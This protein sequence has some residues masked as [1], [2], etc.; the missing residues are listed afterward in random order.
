MVVVGG[1]NSSNTCHLAA[2]SGRRGVTTFHI[3]DSDGID[4]VAGTIRHQPVGSKTETVT[5]GWLEGVHRIGLTAGAS[6]PNNKIGETVARI[7]ASAGI[8]LG[9]ALGRD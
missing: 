4:P 3:E 9:P 6:T 2:L 5:A 7:A 1:Y 8:D